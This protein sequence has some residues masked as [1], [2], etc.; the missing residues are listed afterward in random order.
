MHF[1]RATHTN[2]RPRPKVAEHIIHNVKSR[3][4]PSCTIPSPKLV[5]QTG[6]GR[7]DVLFH[8]HDR[9]NIVDQLANFV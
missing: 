4:F 9:S 2:T 5:I 7:N 6:N 1:Y 8:F 3:K